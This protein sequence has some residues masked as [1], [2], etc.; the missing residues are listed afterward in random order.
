MLNYKHLAQL[1]LYILFSDIGEKLARQLST[2]D[3]ERETAWCISLVHHLLKELSVNQQYRIDMFSEFI[4][5]TCSGCSEPIGDYGHYDDCS[6][7]KLNKQ[8]GG[9]NKACS[10]LHQTSDRNVFEYRK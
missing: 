9:K 2:P 3:K 8:H 6:L 7:G 10:Y 1:S 5:D 4:N